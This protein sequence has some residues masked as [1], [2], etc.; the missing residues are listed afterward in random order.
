MVAGADAY[1]DGGG[2]LWA[3]AG[4]RGHAVRLLR[5]RKGTGQTLVHIARVSSDARSIGATGRDLM[6]RDAEEARHRAERAGA[7]MVRAVQAALQERA[8]VELCRL[9]WHVDGAEAEDGQARRVGVLELGPLKMLWLS[10]TVSDL[11][12]IHI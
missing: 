12:L 7:A 10:G 5:S 8:P 11:S 6:A 4:A 9:G 3:T 1:E 2:R